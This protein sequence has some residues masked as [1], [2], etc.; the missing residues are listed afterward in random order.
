MENEFNAYLENRKLLS[1]KDKVLLGVSG[2]MDSMVMMSLFHR[3]GIPIGIAHCNF[4]LRGS[5]SDSDCKR[6]KHTC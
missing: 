1:P 6:S 5:D 3:A 2:G 4:Q